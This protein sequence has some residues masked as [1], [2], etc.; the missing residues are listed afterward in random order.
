LR[1]SW[2]VEPPEGIATI[3]KTI[4]DREQRSVGS[5]VTMMVARSI[6]RERIDQ[7]IDA[8]G[9]SKAVKTLEMR[10]ISEWKKTEA[11]GANI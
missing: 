6:D 5:V 2:R 7:A 3:V 1:T 8:A 4:A 10:A 11:L 9:L